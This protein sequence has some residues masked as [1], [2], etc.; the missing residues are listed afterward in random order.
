MINFNSNLLVAENNL[1]S[2]SKFYNK[3]FS[4]LH[5]DF[6]QLSYVPSSRFRSST[7]FLNRVNKMVVSGSITFKMKDEEFKEFYKT[8]E[9]QPLRRTIYEN[10]DQYQNEIHSLISDLNASRSPDE[11]IESVSW[12]GKL[13][14]RFV[15]HPQLN[16]YKQDIVSIYN[17]YMMFTVPEEICNLP[18]IGF[19]EGMA[20][21]CVF[22][23]L[24]DPMYRD[25]GLI[26]GIHYV[27]YDGSVFDL[28]KK[29]Q[30][31]QSHT[32]ELHKI[33]TCG[34]AFVNDHLT[35]QIVYKKFMNKIQIELVKHNAQ[36]ILE[37]VQAQ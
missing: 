8:D 19:I 14:S 6:Y 3:Y 35:P 5:T 31:Y 9:L 13:R 29:V 15:A 20:C 36:E 37:D 2:N 30:F 16:Y 7:P 18:A 26:P 34:L 22:F 32:T 28:I 12:L 17:S 11:K 23:G 1:A 10:A 24:D 27:S 4:K 25:L 33:A 21:G